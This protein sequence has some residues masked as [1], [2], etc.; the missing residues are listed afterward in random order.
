M[1]ILLHVGRKCSYV[2]TKNL[3]S[4]INLLLQ[5]QDDSMK[6]F[7]RLDYNKFL[8]IFSK[9]LLKKELEKFF[10]LQ[11]N[12]SPSWPIAAKVEWY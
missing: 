1:E 12:P 5:H 3:F 6:W 10:K 7:L 9:I 2:F 8:A 4:N 11:H